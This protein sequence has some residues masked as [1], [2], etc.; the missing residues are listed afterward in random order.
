LGA[1]I[2]GRYL[3]TPPPRPPASQARRGEREKNASLQAQ[4]GREVADGHRDAVAHGMRGGRN[5]LTAPREI[6]CAGTDEPRKQL[7]GSVPSDRE[8]LGPP[9]GSRSP[10]LARAESRLPVI[11]EAGGRGGGVPCGGGG[12]RGGVVPDATRPHGG[13]VPCGGGGTGVEVPP[14]HALSAGRTTRASYSAP[15]DEG[16]R[17]FFRC[18]AQRAPFRP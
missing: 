9:L 14:S 12:T 16:R 17:F 3:G 4:P 7:A 2:E 18:L 5:L 8:R 13:G 1:R 11:C 10:R 6:R 15:G